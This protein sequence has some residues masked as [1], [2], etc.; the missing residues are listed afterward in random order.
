MRPIPA[1]VLALLMTACASTPPSSPPRA[2][3][4]NPVPSPHLAEQGTAG[5]ALANLASAS[6]SLVSG[7]VALAAVPGGVRIT[8]EVGGLVRNGAHS[9]QVHQR[10]DCS[11]ADASSAGPYFDPQAGAEQVGV[12]GGNRDRIVADGDGLARV[13]LLVPRAVLGGG[14]ANDIAGRALLVLGATPGAF[15]ARVAC[16]PIEIVR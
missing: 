14:A 3:G 13:D 1:V 7:R 8:G 16:G 4:A 9:L 5:A 6:G 12:V 11:A 10:G 15:S 2:G